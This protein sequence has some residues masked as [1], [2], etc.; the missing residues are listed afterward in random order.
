MHVLLLA[1]GFAIFLE[2]VVLFVSPKLFR[3]GMLRLLQ[4]GD[5]DLRILGFFAIVAAVGI[6]YLARLGY[7]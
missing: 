2:G 3:Q 1:I 5:R 4:A 7:G 6:M